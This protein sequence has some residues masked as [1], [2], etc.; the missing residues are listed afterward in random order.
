MEMVGCVL[1][2]FASRWVENTLPIS[3]AMIFK[4][5]ANYLCLSSSIEKS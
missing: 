4:V 5:N 3:K 1:L 2:I